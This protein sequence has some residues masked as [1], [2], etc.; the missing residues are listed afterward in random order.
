MMVSELFLAVSQILFKKSYRIGEAPF[1]MI[2]ERKVVARG[3]GSVM[4]C[5]EDS[6]AIFEVA[7]E[8]VN[9]LGQTVYAFVRA[10]KAMASI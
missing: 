7:F 9:C 6:F 1:L 2:R 4:A 8:Q 3:K 10:R 5:P